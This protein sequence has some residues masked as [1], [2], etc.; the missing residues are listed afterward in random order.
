[1]R[2]AP[3]SLCLAL[4]ACATHRESAVHVDE[5]AQQE[6]ESHAAESVEIHRI[7]EPSRTVTVV[8]EFG[9]ANGAGGGQVLPASPAQNL[10]ASP[11]VLTVLPFHGPLIK[12]TTITE[13]RGQVSE[14]TSAKGSSE[15]TA[16]AT[17]TLAAKADTEKDSKPSLGLP[18]LGLLLAGIAASAILTRGIWLMPLFSF[19]KSKFGGST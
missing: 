14:T 11:E 2:G 16:A 7:E 3:L 6:E 17:A 1:V 13:E 9:E 10:S 8:E 12:L 5:A 18:Y 15:S 4:F 19:L